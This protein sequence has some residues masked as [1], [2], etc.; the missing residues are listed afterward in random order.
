[1]W[2][3]NDF[4]RRLREEKGYYFGAIVC[5]IQFEYLLSNRNQGTG[6]VKLAR[7]PYSCGYQCTID[8]KCVRLCVILSIFKFTNMFSY[9]TMFIIIIRHRKKKSLAQWQHIFCTRSVWIR[10]AGSSARKTVNAEVKP[11]LTWPPESPESS[12]HGEL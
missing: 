12:V 1:M 8:S 4:V 2:V 9:P 6:Y 11:T 5:T 3:V 7:V 10:I